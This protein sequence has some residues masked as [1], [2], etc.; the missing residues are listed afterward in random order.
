MSD[1]QDN[2][3]QAT[4]P[5][6]IISGMLEDYSLSQTILAKRLGIS[7][8]H[9]SNL[10]N[11]Q[12][13]ITT[14]MAQ[15]LSLV[16]ATSTD[17][18]LSLQKNHD[19]IKARITLEEQFEQE[20]E[21]L[22][23]YACYKELS[24][25]EYIP[26]SR[27]KFERYVNLLK[28]FGVARLSLVKTNYSVAFRNVATNPNV[29]NSAAWLRCGEIAFNNIQEHKEFDYAKFKGSLPRIRQLTS[30]NPELAFSKLINICA[31]SGVAVIYT[32][33]I[34]KTG[35]KGATRWMLG[36]PFIQLSEMHK[37]A[38][39]VWFSFFHEAAHIIL[40]HSKKRSF[41]DWKASILTKDEYEK[42]AD[43]YA[44][45]TLIPPEM[46]EPFAANGDF[47]PTAIKG[48]AKKLGIGADIVAGRLVH[49]KLIPPQ[50]GNEFIRSVK[51]QNN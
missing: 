31:E 48:F 3:Q 1:Y 44:R 16:F 35:L 23:D 50:L 37:R 43:A 14:E 26:Y 4:H 51:M 13:S 5:G 42:E 47:E 27:K 10:I 40:M 2:S 45:D 41:I 29:T 33:Y 18:W 24:D 9:L 8:K 21:L 17:F 11:R 20:K 46:Y 30:K 34:S 32:P 22:A 25:I 19:T 7:E 28:F 15:K 36:K 6:E 49:E 38:D 39:A 12:T